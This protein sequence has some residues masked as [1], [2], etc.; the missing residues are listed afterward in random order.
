MRAVFSTSSGMTLIS[1]RVA[2]FIVVIHIISGSFSPSPLLRWIVSFCP[3][4][5][6]KIFAFSGSE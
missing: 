6:A 4:S 5:S 1:R 2:G 3:S